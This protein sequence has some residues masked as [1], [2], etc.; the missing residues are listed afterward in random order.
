MRGSTAVTALG[1]LALA[2]C[3]GVGVIDYVQVKPSYRPQRFAY[4][5]GGRD[6]MTDIQGN[7][8]AMLQE[9]FNA[10][11]TD[12]M[13]RAHFG[14]AT[15]FTTAPGETARLNYRVRL[16]F[17]GP[18]ASTGAIV[19]GGEPAAIAPSPDGGNVR[20]LAAFCNGER[21]LSYLTAHVGGIQ[22]AHDPAFRDFMRQ[23][24]INLF[25]PQNRLEQDRNCAPPGDC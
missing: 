9:E 16:L 4:A 17:N 10:A 24:T 3:A 12:A 15:N 1:L 20:L 8:F 19:C 14:P 22:D 2:G 7:P 18:A 11:V 23:V 25:P 21:P 13:Q 6:L 5:A